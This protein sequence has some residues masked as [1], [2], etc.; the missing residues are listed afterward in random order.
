MKILDLYVGKVLLTYI[1][2]TVMVLIGLFT[3]VSFIDELGDLDKGQYGIVQIIQ[4]VVF[5]IPNILYEIFP[6]AALIGSVLG[7]SALA[8]NSEL[9]VMRASGV[10]IQRIVLS[11]L[12][13]G[14][15]LAIIAVIMGEI[16]SPF[17]ETR[18]QKVR[19]EA[20]HSGIRQEQNAGIWLRDD[21]SFVN[22]GEVLPDL[23][24][25]NIKIFE[26]DDQN[27]LRFLSIAQKGEY[28]N[29]QWLLKDLKR[30]MIRN[31]SSAADVVTAANWNTQVRPDILKVFMSTPDQFSIWQ[32]SQYINHLKANKQDTS[33]YELEYW[34][35]IFTPIATAV[36][37]TLAVPFAFKDARSGGLGRDLFFGIM[38]G[39]GFFILNKAFS[40]FVPLFS[41]PP[42]I[43][44]V[45]PTLLV[46]MLSVFL[47]R[48]IY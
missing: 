30:T 39:L 42:F 26:F 45:I 22:I 11:V 40:Y 1:L 34:G 43:G 12:Q 8:R 27:F 38:I 47:I 46:S 3:F 23:T 37:L 25:L 9:I 44:S 16:I 33:D 6:M 19:A 21:N 18:A 5:S 24:L 32:L 41:I 17:T 29:G 7:L 13:V 2:V 35:K 48:R 4:Y 15:V 20:V 10:S 14:A 31:E 36:M 28:N